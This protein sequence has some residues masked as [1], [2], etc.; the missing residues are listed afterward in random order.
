M[1]VKFSTV[2]LVASLEYLLERSRVRLMPGLGGSGDDH[3][4]SW[5]ATWHHSG[6]DTWHS[7]HWM[8]D[9]QKEASR[10][11]RVSV[12]LEDHGML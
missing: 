4:V 8:S 12:G 9:L 5:K 7:N 1:M 11:L 2:G 3:R 6:G 10:C